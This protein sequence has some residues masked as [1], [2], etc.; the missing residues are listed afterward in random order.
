MK[1]TLLEWAEYLPEKDKQNFLD[2]TGNGDISSFHEKFSNL[3]SCIQGAFD[4]E[5]AENYEGSGY[6]YDLYCK[7]QDH[8]DHVF[9]NEKTVDYEIC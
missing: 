9:I 6:W 3:A 2:Y 7:A 8:G 1:K 4:W 5:D